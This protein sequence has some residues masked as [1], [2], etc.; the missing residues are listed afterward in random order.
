MP[1]ADLSSA[2]PRE[3]LWVKLHYEIRPRKPG[4]DLIARVW[5]GRLDD[6]VVI[7]GESGDVFVKLLAPQK[8]SYQAPVTVELKL[9][10]VAYKA[11]SPDDEEGGGDA[12]AG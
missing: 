6:A 3:A 2:V 12:P 8:I 5:S 10:V 9:K 4:A 1:D 11:P 7:K